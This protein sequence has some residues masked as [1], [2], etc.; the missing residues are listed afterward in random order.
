[1]REEGMFRDEARL[2][3][4]AGRGGDGCC[5]F[6]REKYR[7]FGGPAGGDGGRGGS[8]ALEAVP[9]E[10]SLFSLGRQRVVRA[11][12]GKPG[13]GGGRNGGAGEDRLLPV[14]VGTQVRDARH[15]HLL[16]D[17]TFPGSTLVVARGGRGGRGNARFAT[18]TNQAPRHFEHGEPGEE[19]E[20]LLVL[21]LMA[22]IGLVGLPNA[23]KSTLLR[24]LTAARPQVGAYPFTTLDP[25]LGVIE[26]PPQGGCLV[27]ADIPGLVAGAHR[28][29]GLGTR[30]LR[31]LERTRALL[32]LVDCSPLGSDPLT[33]LKTVEAELQAYGG[34]LAA[35]PRLI[36]A[37]KVEDEASQERAAALLS[38]A[39]IG[40]LAVSAW[41]GKGLPELRS[42]LPRLL[43][44]G[45]PGLDPVSRGGNKDP[46]ASKRSLD[47]PPGRMGD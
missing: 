44:A 33:A 18:A 42:M 9:N 40:G 6:F 13:S 35:R 8:V 47:T 28:G 3:A 31:H 34:D 38:Q 24:R 22:D 29:K 37:T 12:G 4:I 30:F 2:R 10:D 41:T 5:A 19:R 15:G 11:P 1:M 43:K 21:K 32:H 14:P 25:L 16:A 36:V 46:E 20:V 39:G 17:L 23:G 7:P 26:E 27:L 45:R